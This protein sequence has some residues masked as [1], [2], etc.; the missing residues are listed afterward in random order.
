MLINVGMCVEIDRLSLV[1][2]VLVSTKCVCV[3]LSVFMFLTEMTHHFIVLY[4]IKWKSKS[5]DCVRQTV[6]Q[7]TGTYGFIR[8]YD[9]PSTESTYGATSIRIIHIS[10][11]PLHDRSFTHQII[12][13]K[14]DH[15]HHVRS[16]THQIVHSMSDHARIR[17]FT[18]QIIH[19][20]EHSPIRS[21]TNQNNHIPDCSH[22]TE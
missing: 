15:S 2:W 17:S 13:F 18:C 1:S 11:H 8:V 10:D 20:S 3:V 4:C 22:V 21:S 6:Q 12:H 5:P 19:L 9:S 16:S 7:R 14:S